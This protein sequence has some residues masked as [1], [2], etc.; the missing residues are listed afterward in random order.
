MLSGVTFTTV[1]HLPKAAKTTS[2]SKI[3]LSDDKKTVRV[4]YTM[5]D[6]MKTPQALE[7]KVEY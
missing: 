3:S 1:I 6:M 7:F 5:Q 4:K 2:G